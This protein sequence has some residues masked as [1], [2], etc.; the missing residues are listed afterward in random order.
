MQVSGP[1]GLV[2]VGQ[3]KGRQERPWVSPGTLS[4]LAFTLPKAAV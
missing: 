2:L 4:D 3:A 1:G